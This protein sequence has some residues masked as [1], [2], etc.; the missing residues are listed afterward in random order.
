MQ[1]GWVLAWNGYRTQIGASESG[2]N[3]W[4][5]QTVNFF[6]SY[7]NT[8]LATKLALTSTQRA[9]TSEELA[10]LSTGSSDLRLTYETTRITLADSIKNTKLSLEQA[11]TAY[12]NA[13][14][15]K[16][17]TITQLFATK[18]NAEI[19][20]EQ[21]RRDYA[22]LR[23]VAPVDGTI[24]KVTGSVG[25]SVSIGS[26]IADFTSKQPQMVL[27]LDSG[28]AESLVIGDTVRVKVDDTTLSGTVTAVSTVSNANL[29]STVRI[30]VL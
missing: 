24:S 1:D 3:S 17:A 29:L 19:S 30:A 14:A 5:A 26:P 7:K 13:E 25:Q 15:L 6:D 4:K 23:I 9:L 11:D 18:K 10:L 22:K 20:L 12:K 2:F 16:N 21:A 28:L 8:E 27:D